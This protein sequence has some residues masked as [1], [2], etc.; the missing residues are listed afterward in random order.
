MSSTSSKA[1]A[2]AW[3]RVVGWVFL[4][5]LGWCL[6][7]LAYGLIYGAMEKEAVPVGILPS[8]NVSTQQWDTGY[9]NARGSFR[10]IAAEDDGDELTINTVDITCL[11]A[12]M[13]CVIATASE[14]D[15]FMNLDVSHYDVDTWDDKQIR[16]GDTSSICANWTYVIDRPAGTVS[17]LRLKKAVIPE[18]AKKSI[19]H[20]CEGMKD[21]RIAL[22][23]G[24]Q[25][26][27]QKIQAFENKNLL[28]LHLFLAALNLA[29]CAF[30]ARWVQRRRQR[31]SLK[32][33]EAA[34]P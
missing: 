3:A 9:L 22:V 32:V 26:R 10:N 1:K 24:D 17:G 25:I 5:F 20:P 27:A 12:S 30:I 15:S 4:V 19:M 23:R 8:L 34:A 33:G 7:M 13:S 28:G 2:Q 29:Y 14:F 16:F 31:V 21:I 6:V 11:K 18:Y